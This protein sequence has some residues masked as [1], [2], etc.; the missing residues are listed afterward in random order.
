MSLFYY[1]EDK[2]DKVE[3]LKKYLPPKGGQ[4]SRNINMKLNSLKNIPAP[5]DK[6]AVS[7]LYLSTITNS[8][9]H[10]NLIET[11][12]WEYYTEKG[13]CMFRLKSAS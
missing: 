1:Y 10:S 5:V 6:D 8:Y 9:I 13:E 12:I 3:E 11:L 4:M 7:K 2:A